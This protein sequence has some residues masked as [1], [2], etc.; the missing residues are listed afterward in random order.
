MTVYYLFKRN[1]AERFQLEL[2]VEGLRQ[3][4]SCEM[5]D[6]IFAGPSIDGMTGRTRHFLRRMSSSG[7]RAS[8]LGVG[9]GA[10]FY[11]AGITLAGV[12]T[13][14]VLFS[15]GF[16]SREHAT[17]E[18]VSHSGTRQAVSEL[19]PISLWVTRAGEVPASAAT[20]SAFSRE[21]AVPQPGERQASKPAEPNRFGK[22]SSDIVSGAVAEVPDAMTWVV[23]NNAVYLWGIRPG[24]QSQD[25]SLVRFVDRV[26]AKGSIECH[27]H[28]HSSRYR[29]ATATG[30]DIAEAALLAG[31]GRAADGATVAYRDAEA[32]AR[33]KGRGLWAKP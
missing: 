11:L 20:N 24:S 5:F 2:A 33:R 16:Y 7:R 10:F 28:P 12:V 4:G 21:P 23:A 13:I 25:A 22:A 32:E 6:Q 19:L 27:R 15:A 8:G 30:E 3:G 1:V 31:V 14:G 26:R 9:V 18:N 17:A 29:C